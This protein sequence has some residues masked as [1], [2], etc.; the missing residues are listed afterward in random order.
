MTRTEKEL[1]EALAVVQKSYM[2]LAYERA[3]QGDVF[4][5]AKAVSRSNEAGRRLDKL[6][7]NRWVA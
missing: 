3:S 7:H 4:A 6:N 1:I 2:D 5:V